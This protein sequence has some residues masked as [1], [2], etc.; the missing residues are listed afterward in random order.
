[1]KILIVDDEEHIRKTFQMILPDWGHEVFDA[2]DAGS[3]LKILETVACQ[4]VIT[5]LRMPG[6][7]GEEGKRTSKTQ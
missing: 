6:V 3:A 2:P 5:D 4:A 1:M 7:S